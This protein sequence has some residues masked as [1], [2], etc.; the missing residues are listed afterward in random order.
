MAI[1]IDV[2]PAEIQ[3]VN[4]PLIWEVS[5]NRF[6]T[7]AF[8]VTSVISEPSGPFIGSARFLFG[9]SHPYQVGDILNGTT[10]TV[11]SYNRVHVV[12]QITATTVTTD[13]I[14]V[15]TDTGLMTRRNNNF[16]IRVDVGVFDSIAEPSKSIASA[17]AAGILTKFTTTAPHGY[18]VGDLVEQTNTTT[19]D[20]FFE[21]AA[22]DSTTEYTLAVTFVATTTGDVQKAPVIGSIRQ[23]VTVEN[24]INL[25]RFSIAGMLDA[26]ISGDLL[27]LDTTGITTP[28]PNSIKRYVLF[29]L[30]EYDLKPAIA[31]P[32]DRIFSA[33]NFG[34]N[35]ADQHRDV[36]TVVRFLLDGPTK[37]FL[38]NA[39]LSLPKATEEEF[40]LS[41]ITDDAALVHAR[42]E[43]FDLNG[44]SLG[45]TNSGDVT[46]VDKRAIFAINDDIFDDIHSKIEVFIAQE[47]NTQISEIRTFIRDTNCYRNPIRFHWLNR[48]GG[49]DAHTFT[50]DFRETVK[51]RKTT[52]RRDLGTTVEKRERGTTILGTAGR[53]SFRVFSEFVPT[54]TRQWL[55]EIY[56]SPDVFLEEGDDLIPVEITS[57]SATIDRAKLIQL[58]IDWR[59]ANDLNTQ[60][61]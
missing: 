11:S 47:D 6:G 38:T 51:A 5:S 44:A 54:A 49:H 31:E 23:Q 46:I 12:V 3:S 61:N 25:W 16:R 20:G 56:T 28:T 39:P 17:V 2:T 27:D 53:P 10:F 48:A 9:V 8:P 33:A 30:E 14:F 59:E 18:S 35:T 15:S 34:I 32:N 36:Q 1:T 21:V 50:G 41:F 52:Y 22:I 40:Q 4:R 19:Y 42:F 60:G 37:R 43:R 26:L 45:F 58:R 13:T 7:E 57:R 24:A 29:F 55:E